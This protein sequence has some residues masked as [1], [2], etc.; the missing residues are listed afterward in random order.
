MPP[1]VPSITAAITTAKKLMEISEK[2]KDAELRNL[3]GDLNLK[4]ADIKIQLANV[5]DENIQLKAKIKSLEGTEGEKCPKCRRPGWQLESST[6]HP[7][8]GDV[9][10]VQ[11][12]YKCSLCGFSESK[13]ITPGME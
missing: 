6:R 12:L 5:I 13:L 7:I 3:I 9:G 2:I 4:L 1:I 8:F 10:G 11:R